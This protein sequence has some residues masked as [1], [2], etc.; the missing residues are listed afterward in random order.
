MKSISIKILGNDDISKELFIKIYIIQKK[1]IILIS[2]FANLIFIYNISKKV[3][4]NTDNKIQFF[5]ED[6]INFSEYNTPI[7]A[8]AI[9][10]NNL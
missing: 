7:K 8:I 2:F 3:K 5:K 1:F 10:N 6:N 9:Y 4:L